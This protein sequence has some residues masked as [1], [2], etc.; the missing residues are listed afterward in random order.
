MDHQRFP[1]SAR[2]DLIRGLLN[3]MS[4]AHAQGFIHRDLKP[5]NIMVGPYGEVTVMDW[6]LARR[7]TSDHPELAPEVPPR[8]GT[9]LQT[10]AGSLLG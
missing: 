2:V 4:Y 5:A 7:F 3:A 6:G 9:P 10:M 1:F 8:A